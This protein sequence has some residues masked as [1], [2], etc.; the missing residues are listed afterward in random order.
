MK[1]LFTA[2]I[3]KVGINPCVKVPY[4]ITEKMTPTRGFIPIKGQIENHFFQQTLVPVKNSNFRLYVNGAMLK[5]AG[6]KVGDTVQ[7]KIEQNFASWKKV[8]RMPSA[9][10]KKLDEGGLHVAFKNLTPSRQKEVLRY[11]NY[12]KTEESVNRNIDKVIRQLAVG[13]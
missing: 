10:R 1:H 3:Y 2:K 11:L 5:G 7:F 12:L 8:I 13:S 6:I 9:F 4:R